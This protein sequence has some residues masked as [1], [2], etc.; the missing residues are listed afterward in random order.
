MPRLV[1]ALLVYE[2]R[3][4]GLP[5]PELR[6]ARLGLD[7]ATIADLR[8]GAAGE[9]AADEI[10]VDYAPAG[11]VRGRVER[12]LL[13]GLRVAVRLDGTR[14]S[15]GSL[16]AALA[17]L[18]ATIE[19]GDGAARPPVPP[20]VVESARI[21]LAT[22]FGPVALP[23]GGELGLSP[24]GG[25]A[26]DFA[27]AAESGFGRLAGRLTLTLAGDAI[28]GR[29]EIAEGAIAHPALAVTAVTG[30]M[31]FSATPA[32]LMGA[33]TRL[34]VV[35]LGLPTLSPAVATAVLSAEFSP[36]RASAAVELRDAAGEF[37]LTAT[38]ELDGLD[39]APRLAA[40]ANFDAPAAAAPW[41]LVGLPAPAAGA[42][43]LSATLAVDL[44]PLAEIDAAA[45]ARPLDLLR[46]RAAG[47]ARFDLAGL[48]WPGFVGEGAA[49]GA[50]DLA[51]EDDALALSAAAPLRLAGTPDAT[52]LDALDL[53]ADLRA[54]AAGPLDL[55][56][57]V[58]TLRLRPAGDRA[59]LGVEAA[60]A[61]KSA[62]PA[63]LS[64]RLAGSAELD[65]AGR[66][67]RFDLTEARLE[68]AGL[69]VAGAVVERAALTATLAGTPAATAGAAGLDIAVRNLR[70]AGLA[71]KSL[72]LNA[73]ADIAL[74][75]DRLTARLHDDGAVTAGGLTVP[76]LSLGTKPL[77]LPLHAADTAFLTVTFAAAATRLDHALAIG[78]VKFEARLQ[79]DGEPLP[80]RVALPAV[81]L[82]GTWDAVEGYRGMA[83]LDGGRVELPAQFAAASGIAAEIALGS[84]AGLRA[85]YS[86]VLTHLGDPPLVVPLRLAGTAA[87]HG[88][89]LD[90]AARL[91]D[92]DKRIA[93]E[94]TGRHDLAA[95]SGRL[96]LD[97]P[98]LEFAPDGLKPRD[99]APA[100]AGR[101]DQAAG[102]VALAGDVTWTRGRVGADLKLLLEDLSF[103]TP[104]ASVRRL[105]AVIA[106][107][108]LAPLSTPPGQ[109]VAVGMIDAGLPLTDGL[110]TFRLEPGPKL[111][112]ANGRLQLAG[113]GVRVG[114]VTLDPAAARQELRLAVTGVD[115]EQV[116][117]LVDIGGLAGTG[118][119][120]GEIPLVIED[121]QLTVTDGVLTAEAPGQVSYR[122]DSPPDALQAGGE[123]V[124]LALSALTDFRYDE[125]RLNLDR[126]AGGDMV[127]AI[128]IKGINPEFYEGYPVEFNL[129]IS[130]K[131]DQ[132]L[133]RSLAGYRVPDTIRDKLMEFPQR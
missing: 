130:G 92:A 26:G 106:F 103:T 48:D 113:G 85:K 80:L 109:T 16:D 4:V 20:F 39:G 29:V 73:G 122:P 98:R 59:G 8:L 19:P 128:H 57:D 107:D 61:L 116:L 124:S 68:L 111:A 84:A 70:V 52:G 126:T 17:A 3:A 89:R 37:V 51:V 121:G 133:D 104:Q 7:G 23:F 53:P 56:V 72:T 30:E 123:S 6:V 21:D 9:V 79:S 25:L 105:N 77:R 110:L 47:T 93:A 33:T 5:D 78:P 35:G 83:R 114:P 131:L 22:P 76:G 132:V 46:G 2:L 101:I 40:V 44:P 120:S 36:S 28:D 63:A 27:L 117:G 127:V 54:A 88:R 87:F 55:S 18:G 95:G 43:R 82:S 97:M 10:V 58:L 24:A 112:I 74:D 50:L 38:A 129:N 99:L 67:L 11:L 75:G 60:F 13:R 94:A 64:G 66:L 12:V 15:L 115:L 32:G 125:L 102:A 91:A 90:F 49:A 108:G 71:A 42:I 14:P 45:L 69:T 31:T 119:L 86:A 100:L 65:G 118:R 1:A 34:R 81:A 41:P 62:G 96:R